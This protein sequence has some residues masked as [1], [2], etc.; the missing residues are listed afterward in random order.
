MIAKIVKGQDFSG[1]VNYVLNPEKQAELLQIEG[2]RTKDHQSIIESFRIQAGMNSRIKSP[3]GHIS[4]D[5]SPK[6]KPTLTSERMQEIADAYRKAMEIENTQ[7]LLVRHYDKEH[8]HV[9]LVFNRVDD[10]GKTISDKNDRYRSEK[11][12]KELTHQFGLYFAKGKEQVNSHRLKEPDKTK[13]RI[14]EALKISLPGCKNW[15]ELIDK[16]KDVQITVEFKFRGKTSEVQGVTFAMNG[17]SFSGSKVD[18]Q[19]SFS[20]ITAQMESNRKIELQN[21]R[22]QVQHGGNQTDVPG[23]YLTSLIRAIDKQNECERRKERQIVPKKAKR[24]KGPTM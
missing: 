21:Q 18:R 19:F 20:M 16:L 10:E 14:Y 4:L 23:N 3:V 8:P 2:L 1:V 7:Y 11:I 15:D 5:F 17:Y 9:H 6:D 12:C 13:Y 24:R 22:G